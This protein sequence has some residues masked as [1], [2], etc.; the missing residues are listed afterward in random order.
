VTNLEKLLRLGRTGQFGAAGRVVRRWLYSECVAVGL[1]RDLSTPITARSPTVSLTIRPL[2]PEDVPSFVELPDRNGNT[3]D[4]LVRINARHLL[5]SDLA[6]CYVAETAD[7]EVCYMQ[8]LVLPDQNEKLP[9]VFGS[10]QPPL[11]R[12]EALIEFAFTLE[13]YR[14]RGVMPYA[15]SQL[16]A[17]ARGE[18]ARWLVTYVDRREAMLLRFYERMGFEAFRLRRERYRFLRRRVAFTPLAP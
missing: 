5:D 15:M 14:A 4:A 12:D 6:T 16:A 17:E 7:G 13:A 3:P 11:E 9:K 2:R 18:G 8:Y 10:L 1:R